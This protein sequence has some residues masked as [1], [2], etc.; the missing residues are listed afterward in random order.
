MFNFVLCITTGIRL[1]PYLALVFT[2]A[3]VMLSTRVN[4][5]N[6]LKLIIG[7]VFMLYMSCVIA[8]VFFP[9]PDAAEIA[10]LSGHRIQ[11]IPFMYL[12]D[13]IRESPLVPGDASTY[14]PALCNRAIWQV[15][16]NI[17]MMVPL[18]MFLGY[19][20]KCNFRAVIKYTFLLSLFIEIGQL[21]GLFFI[22]KGSYRLCDIDDIM[23]NTLGGA[24]GYGL[25]R[26]I[27]SYLPNYDA[28]DIVI[29]EGEKKEQLN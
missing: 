20:C 1:F 5:L 22:F 13:I 6:L 3:S 17:V 25:L 29:G 4:R 24:I 15:I 12:A 8:L 2:T 28:Y 9:L 19:F 26:V 21:T 16:F 10:E 7:N 18:G 11:A 27:K 23:L 14:L